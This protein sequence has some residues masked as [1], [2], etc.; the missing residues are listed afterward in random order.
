MTT[1]IITS[2]NVFGAEGTEA[3]LSAGAKQDGQSTE[4]KTLSDGSLTTPD[5]EI[6][7]TTWTVPSEL[8]DNSPRYFQDDN[9]IF[10]LQSRWTKDG[11]LSSK[12]QLASFSAKIISELELDDGIDTS[13]R[14]EIEAKCGDRTRTF[15]VP[16][17]DFAKV[18][19]WAAEQLDSAAFVTAVPRAE[20]KVAETI[21]RDSRPERRTVFTHTGWRQ[22]DLDWVYLTAEGALGVDGLLP[23]VDVELM[24]PL[25]RY[26]IP[27]Q[28]NVSEGVQTTLAVLDV[29]PDRVTFPLLGTV[30]RSL[31]GPTDFVP[32]LVG[33]TGAGKSVLSA[34]AQQHWGPELDGR[35][36]PGSWSSSKVALESLAFETKDALVV[37]DDYAPGGGADIKQLRSTAEYIIRSVGNQSTRSR[38]QVDGKRRAPRYPR[39]TVMSTGE[40]YPKGA[41]VIGRMF[42]T[43][44]THGDVDFARC[45]P[46]Q[47]AAAKGVLAV[48]LGGFIRW[49]AANLPMHQTWLKQRSLEIRDEVQDLGHNRTPGCVGDLLASWELWCE[50]AS[51]LH[52]ISASEKQVLLTRAL[53]ALT[54]GAAD[55]KALHTEV[56]PCNRF[57]ETLAAV[58]ASGAAHVT[59]PSGNAPSDAGR[60]GW[61]QDPVDPR[62]MRPSGTKI[63]WITNDGLFLIP[64][65]A[66][67]SVQELA[68]KAGDRFDWTQ[69]TLSKRLAEGGHLASTDLQTRKSIT[70]RKT[71]EGVRS[72][73]L[74]FPTNV[75]G[76][77]QVDDQLTLVTSSAASESESEDARVS[78]LDI[79]AQAKLAHLENPF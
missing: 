64:V 25:D 20:A 9:G 77:S 74:H 69:Q 2:A 50:W 41:S 23:D 63:G 16:A 15:N 24:A 48:G 57:V 34:F 70:V 36:L 54:T 51:A 38:G 72:A 26:R 46:I 27:D 53:A 43:Q 75:L 37:I 28:G 62:T 56:D 19:G 21:Q 13:R 1:T 40:D 65:A 4:A 52:Y 49:L 29:A 67:A 71:F 47:E 10:E 33:T 5:A 32:S 18:S 42:N 35:A 68:R 58:L 22:I 14:Y 61:H 30:W 45:T 79:S 3:Q 78:E 76:E 44:I 59:D 66:V 8:P 11:P 17:A 7:T 6:G 12:C 31:L 60:W 39:G 55:Q 73:V